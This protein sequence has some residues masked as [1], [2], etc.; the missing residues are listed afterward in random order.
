MFTGLIEAVGEVVRHEAPRLVV[1]PPTEGM[2]E[3]WALG[4]SIAINGCC[5][6]LVDFAKDLAFDLSEETYART[7]LSH[8]TP[9]TP[10]N[11]ERAMRVGDRLGGHMVQGHVDTTGTLVSLEPSGDGWTMTV[12]AP[13]EDAA[14]LVDKGSVTVDGISLTV[15]EPDATGRFQVAVIPHTLAHTHLRAAQPGQRVN[16]EFDIIAKQVV[17]Y[18]QLRQG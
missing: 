9:G 4:E 17:R 3:P 7:A 13:A 16:L 11:L 6:T 10:V 5:L 14:L 15:V 2:G 12:Q 1:R 8:L 18:L